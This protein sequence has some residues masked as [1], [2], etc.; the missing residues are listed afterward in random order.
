MELGLIE[1]LLDPQIRR[2][3]NDFD[4]LQ[5]P[6]GKRAIDCWSLPTICTSIGDGRPKFRI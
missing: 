6:V 5:Q 3:R 2:A 4:L 1:G